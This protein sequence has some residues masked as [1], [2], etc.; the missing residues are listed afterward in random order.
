MKLA[1]RMIRAALAALFFAFILRGC[2]IPPQRVFDYRVDSMVAG[3]HF[4]FASWEAAAIADKVGQ[5]LWR[6]VENP[7]PVEQKTLVLEYFSTAQRIRELEG[8]VKRIYSTAEREE[9]PL[10]SLPLRLE[11]EKLRQQ[12]ER[13]RSSVEAVLE[14]QTRQ[15]LVSQGFGLLD[16][17]WPPVKFR[18]SRTPLYLVISPRHTIEV[19]KAV[20]LWPDLD[21]EEREAIEEEIDN[22]F[23]VSSLIVGI[24]GLGAYPT[25]IAETPSLQFTLESAAHEWTH[26]YL[27][28]KPLGWHYEDSQDLRTIN[29]TVASIVGEEVGRLVLAAYYPKLV[30]PES[31]Q[32]QQPPKPGEFDFNREMRSIRLTVDRLLAG[33]RVEEA[34]QFMEERRQFLA[35]HSHYI[36]K[37]NQAYFAFYGSYATSPT[38]VDP[39]GDKLKRLR[40]QSPSLKEFVDRVS[41]MTSYEDLERALESDFR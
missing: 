40:A 1:R 39:I 36:R 21:L 7:G 33:G 14:E 25:M 12:Q 24:G 32:E 19:R 20:Y 15:I 41:V 30:P 38:S 18:F 35:S 8:E 4:N 13:K 5:I 16:F 11:L 6:Q 10:A 2:A 37:L 23:D 22:A 3:Q 28:F 31:E 29:E 26:N 17:I 9:A 34:E 27:A